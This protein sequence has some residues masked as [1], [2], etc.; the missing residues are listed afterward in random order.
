MTVKFISKAASK[1]NEER[2]LNLFLDLA[3]INGPSGKEQLVADYLQEELP[4]LGFSVAFDEAYKKFNGDVGNL[5]AW[6]EG[7]DN[8]IPPLFFSTHMD[9]V[10][11]TENLNP[12]IKN[13]IISSDGTTI[14]GA[15]D[16]AALA[17]YIEGFRAVIESGIPHGPIEFILT[18]N[19]QAGLV[20]AKYLD[21]TIPKSKAGYI[22]DSSGDVGQVI[23]QG[24][25]SSRIWFTV[26]GNSAHIALNSEVGNNA[27]LIAAEGLLK[28]KLGEIDNET[29]A[30][31]GIIKGGELTSIIPGSVIFGGEVR[32]FS[33]E[34][35]NRQLDHMKG[36]MEEVANKN[37]ARLDVKIE[38]KYLGFNV[39]EDNK[40]VINVK[41]ATKN[42][43]VSHY[44][45]KTLGGADTNI[46]NE[47]G[48]T[49]ITLGNGFQN[50]HTFNEYISIENLNNT[51]RLTAS[52]IEQWYENHKQ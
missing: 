35:L 13:G 45:T 37:N 51:G 6:H 19:E 30:N 2:L 44:V 17:S 36:I 29:V 38:E 46:L 24:P 11:P 9:T 22:F 31:I 18:V 39:S 7:T 20:G 16:R 23:L 32:S 12:I 34:K 40:L 47:N 43:N 26:H 42:I 25:Y 49:C 10:L 48:L 21:Y 52:L 1:V 4:K 5:I 14:L 28:M 33:Q 27:F 15:D 3:K 41:E 50:I 8:S